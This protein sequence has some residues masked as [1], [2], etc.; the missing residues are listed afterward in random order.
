MAKLTW[1]RRI[2]GNSQERK[3]APIAAGK[4]WYSFADVLRPYSFLK[5]LLRRARLQK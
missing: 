3:T 2:I 1:K 5:H 4:A